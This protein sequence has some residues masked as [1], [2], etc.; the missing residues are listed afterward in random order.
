MSSGGEN[1]RPVLSPR[2]EAPAAAAATVAADRRRH[3]KKARRERDLRSPSYLALRDSWG[4]SD[5]QDGGR[6]RS[7][8]PARRP[9]RR[10][11]YFDDMN[12]SP[13]RS[14]I[15]RRRRSRSN[16]YRSEDD[17]EDDE[18]E[19]RSPSRSPSPRRRRRRARSDSYSHGD[20]TAR[21]SR[22]PSPRRRRRRARSNSYLD[23]YEEEEPDR[24]SPSPRR[25]RVAPRSCRSRSRT[26]SQECEDR[27]CCPPANGERDM[28]P[29]EEDDYFNV[30]I[31]RHD[32][33]FKCAM[34]ND[35]LSPPVY[36]C[37][38][39]H[40]T[41]ASCHDS[42][43]GG[44]VDQASAN[45]NNGGEEAAAADNNN[46]N[47]CPKPQCGVAGYGPSRA[48]AEWLR[49]VRFPCGNSEYGCRAFLPWRE[50]DTEH[51]ATCG[52]APVFCPIRRCVDEGF[53]GGTP[54][55]L[56]RHLTE[57]HGWEVVAFRYGEAFRVRVR[58]AHDGHHPA[59]V[60]LRAGDG[61]LFH[62]RAERERRDGTALSMIRI[63]PGAGAGAAAAAEEFTYEV[64]AAGPRHRVQMQAT[65]W[66]TSL[67]NG[68]VDENPVRVTVPDDMI[69]L[70][71]PDQGSVEVCV[72]QV[73]AAAP[74]AAAA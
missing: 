54:D 24:R 56:E 31:D 23:D 43:N 67:L 50:M 14:P 62:L 45:D 71:G 68:M 74:P 49:S 2:R 66:G 63:R 58:A 11:R 72:R 13:S 3:G 32:H 70:D 53:H 57:R 28:S 30:R 8:S 46:N 22:S 44:E 52:Y 26:R 29:E 60:L 65:V 20:E 36:E 73:A 25:R 64:T 18:P 5:G 12:R 39:G 59:A 35:L 17:D 34:C 9:A 51:E 42:A 33:L 40:V 15:P 47:R 37:V 48:V 4:F 61:R 6:R 55:D 10:S 7:P 38:A 21:R 27:R 69:P 16:S 41:C 19:R 1:R